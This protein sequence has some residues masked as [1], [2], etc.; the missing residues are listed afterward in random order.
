L[1]RPLALWEEAYCPRSDKPLRQREKPVERSAAARGYDVGDMPRHRFDSRVADLDGR[2]GDARRLAQEDAFARIRL[3]ELDPAHT[4]NRQHETG[5]PGAA[6]EVDE[7]LRP[8]RDMG[9]Q[10]RR[11]EK[12]AAPQITERGGANQVDTR[13]PVNQE[14]G[15][16]FE[17]GQCFT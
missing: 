13:R 12:M 16:G 2:R 14:L 1:R 6:A 11:I 9:K 3:D 5:E 4:E 17:P 8:L 10:L 7:A 15:I